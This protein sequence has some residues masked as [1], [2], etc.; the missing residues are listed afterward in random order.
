MDLGLWFDLISNYM[1]RY[2]LSAFPLADLGG[3]G[4]VKPPSYTSLP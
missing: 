4:D 3:G 2:T 1:N